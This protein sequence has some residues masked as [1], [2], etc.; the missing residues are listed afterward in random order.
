MFNNIFTS[1]ESVTPPPKSTKDFENKFFEKSKDEDEILDL[2]DWL[3][4]NPI[5][6]NPKVEKPS[7]E[8]FIV[9]PEEPIADQEA[10]NYQDSSQQYRSNDQLVT[11]LINTG[12]SLSGSKYVSGGH[13]P[14]SGF[15]CSGFLHYVYKQNGVDIPLNIYEMVKTGKEVSL[16]NARPGD[17]ICSKGH[18]RS[19]LHV[20]MI[21]RIDPQTH[22]IYVLEAK[23]KKYGVGEWPLT[24][25]AEDIYSVRRVLNTNPGDPFLTNQDIKAPAP[26]TPMGKFNSKADFVRTLNAGYRKALAKRGIDPNYS[27]IL[28]AQASIESAWG[29][30]PAG[31]Y[32][33]GGIKISKKQAKAHP[34]LA[35]KA[36]TPDY[37]KGKGIEY[38]IQNFRNF[39]SIEDYC[40]YRIN[41]LSNSNYNA[42]NTVRPNNP[43]EFAMHIT[44]KGYGADRGGPL[45]RKY[46]S[47]EV[48]RYNKVLKYLR[49]TPSI[50]RT[51]STQSSNNSPIISTNYNMNPN[52]FQRLIHTDIEDLLKQEGITSV[53]GKRIKFGTKALRPANA[54]F[55]AKNSNHKKKDPLTGFANARDISI[56][57]G[58][59]K[60]YAAFRR[61]LLSNPRV[62][63]WMRAR[64]WGIINE[65]TP[66]ILSR[67]RGTGPHFHF[68]PDKWAYRTWN[69]WLKNPNVSITQAM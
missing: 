34:E 56:I 59:L 23:G 66:A 69:A 54:S 33:Y 6:S 27:Y 29:S 2:L 1:Y 20:Q 40:N 18:G 7:E 51:R 28:T 9:Q 36:R 16:S 25:K 8:P 31:N 17:I 67:T 58:N 5:S 11:N 26:S 52:D 13:S 35:H 3:S 19:G 21:S 64:N 46:A 37:I 43:Y 10:Q 32:N 61:I 15:D 4:V 14:S 55:G 39:S 53:N 12:K 65:V 48:D 49:S 44:R 50:T 30:S 22:Q 42:F 60:D 41:L 57:N 24:K 38:R 68:G 62:V 63:A 45:S 47:W